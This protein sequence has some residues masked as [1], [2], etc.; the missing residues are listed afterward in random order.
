MRDVEIPDMVQT[1]NKQTPH[2]VLEINLSYMGICEEC[3]KKK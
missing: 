1:V 3:L 2:N